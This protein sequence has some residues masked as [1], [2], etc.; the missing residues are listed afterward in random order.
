[1]PVDSCGSNSVVF[2]LIRLAIKKRLM[3]NENPSAHRVSDYHWIDCGRL[4]GIRAPGDQPLPIVVDMARHFL[5][6][7][8]NPLMFDSNH[9]LA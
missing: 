5:Q 2:F 4:P 1:M 7:S 8:K 9:H 3:E 6:P